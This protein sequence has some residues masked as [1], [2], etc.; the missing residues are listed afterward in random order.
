MGRQSVGEWMAEAMQVWREVD[1]WAEVWVDGRWMNDE[2]NGQGG[3]W[4]VI[5]E[6]MGG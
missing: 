6:C 2:K 3:R 5:E 1:G 4:M